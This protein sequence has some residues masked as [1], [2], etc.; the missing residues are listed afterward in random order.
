M[1][2]RH[3]H[4]ISSSI[5]E[6]FR[7]DFDMRVS[8][9]M[10]GLSQAIASGAFA[11]HILTSSVLAGTVNPV[12]LAELQ[13][14]PIAP[15]RVF[16]THAASPIDSTGRTFLISGTVGFEAPGGTAGGCG[17]PASANAV[18]LSLTVSGASTNGMLAAYPNGSPEDS[19]ALAF[20]A[21]FN[22]TGSVNVGL[23]ASSIGL[24]TAG[25]FVQ[26][27]GDVTGYFVPQIE[28]VFTAEGNSTATARVVD[29]TH[30]A[31]GVYTLLL[32]RDVTYCSVQLLPVKVSRVARAE[33]NAKTLIVRTYA[34]NRYLMPSDGAVYFVVHC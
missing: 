15:C 6:G 16:D 31:T 33:L 24:K 3:L 23:L 9:L 19:I 10:R 21:R 13:F 20:N 18:A 7:D 34:N 8:S 1:G 4:F 22:D 27:T 14:V 32:D 30:T 2:R 28:G 11:C 29:I 26:A 5:A 25:G 17:V 12:P